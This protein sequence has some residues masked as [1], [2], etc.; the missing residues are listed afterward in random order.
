[1]GIIPWDKKASPKEYCPRS[2][3]FYIILIKSSPGSKAA[4]PVKQGNFSKA[5]GET[6]QTIRRQREK[7]K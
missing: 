6:A 5:E 1:M 3:G 2:P 4:G 7:A